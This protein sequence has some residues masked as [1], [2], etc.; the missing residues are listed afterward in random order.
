[1]KINFLQLL[2]FALFAII[3]IETCGGKFSFPNSRVI[4]ICIIIHDGLSVVDQYSTLVNPECY[5][6]SFYTQ[7]SGITN[8]M[9]RTAPTFAQIAKTVYEMTFDKTFVAHNVNFD[10]NFIAGEFANLGFEYKRPKLCTVQ[11]SRRLM[12]GYKSYSLGKFCAEIGITIHNRHRAEG[13]A[14]ATAELFDRLLRL[15]K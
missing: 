8:E 14:V 7:I 6:S 1:L 2:S 9:V 12:P 15:R 10:Y 5:I 13:D 4:D 3:D 11:M